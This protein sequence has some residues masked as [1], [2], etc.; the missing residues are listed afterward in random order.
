MLDRHTR[1]VAASTLDPVA[2]WLAD[3][4]V[5][6]NYLTALGFVFGFGA[7]G[8]IA[9]G[10]WTLG[11]GLW[12]VNRLFDGL[13]GLVARKSEPSDLG[14]FLDLSADFA[15]YAGFVVAVAIAL[16]HARLVSVVLLA[17]YYLSG[18]AFLTW[19][20]LVQKQASKPVHSEGERSLAFLPGLAE[21][22][23]TIVVYCLICIVPSWAV[24]I[25][26]TFAGVVLITAGQRI[27]W[28][29]KTLR[30]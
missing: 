23:E 28:A 11:L 14:G 2:T 7:C 10:Q 3:R 5:G 6:A 19:S 1:G 4:S 8:A 30:T 25:M 13:D 27:W 12:L 15:I 16:P 22:T 17:T 26:W 21:G 24:P 9:Y 29:T 18:T 20:G